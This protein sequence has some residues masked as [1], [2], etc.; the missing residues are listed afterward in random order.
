MS[1]AAPAVEN[2]DLPALVGGIVRDTGTLM[3]QQVDLLRAEVTQEVRRAGGAAV[4]IA[5]G[6]GLAAAGGL[7]T[8]MMLAHVLQ[9][10]TRLPLW[11]CYGAVGGGIGAAGALLLLQGRDKI[12]N[13]Q[14]VPPQTTE[15]LKENVAWL[16]DQVTP[17][18]P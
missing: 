11:A 8:G 16:K 18:Q 14:L 13:V 9:R 2:L 17:H 3:G 5:A 12:A 15:A 10:T 4:S 1:K 6:G 7:L